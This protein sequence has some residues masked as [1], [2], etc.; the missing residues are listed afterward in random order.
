MSEILILCTNAGYGSI[1]E[2]VRRNGLRTKKSRPK[3][4][5]SGLQ[6]SDAPCM[7]KLRRIA[8]HGFD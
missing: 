4:V 2:E 6:P 5:S 3:L 1:I 8:L 7:K